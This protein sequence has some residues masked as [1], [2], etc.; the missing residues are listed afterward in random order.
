MH[1]NVKDQYQ[2]L[3]VAYSCTLSKPNKMELQQNIAVPMP[4][5]WIPAGNQLILQISPD[6]FLQITRR[7]LQSLTIS[8]FT[9]QWVFVGGLLL[10]A[11]PYKYWFSQTFQYIASFHFS[12]GPFQP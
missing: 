10:Q 12:V 6:V 7:I 1:N 2:S 9:G 5:F 8:T 11:A 4:L 3:K